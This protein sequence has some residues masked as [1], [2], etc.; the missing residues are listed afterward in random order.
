MRRGGNRASLSHLINR[1]RRG[2]PRVTFRTTLIVGYPGETREDYL[3]LK[4]FCREMEFDRL[5]V[6]TYSDEEDTIAYGLESKVSARTA[7]PP[8]Q[9]YGAASAIAGGKT[10]VG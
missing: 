4:N 3:E 5:G 10:G 8:P 6:F 1:V 2:I 9:P 7:T